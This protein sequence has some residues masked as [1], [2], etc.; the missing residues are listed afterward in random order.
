L[1]DAEFKGDELINPMEEI[2]RQP[3]FRRWHGYYWLFFFSKVYSENCDKKRDKES[4]KNLKFAQTASW[5]FCIPV[6]PASCG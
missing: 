1:W 2:S 5:V 6:K 4:L 3:V